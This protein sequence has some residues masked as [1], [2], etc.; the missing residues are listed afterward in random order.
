MSIPTVWSHGGIRLEDTDF[1]SHVAARHQD[2]II[3]LTV[4]T[5]HA[6]T[7][8]L[9]LTNH[10]RRFGIGMVQKTGGCSK[11]KPWSG[12]GRSQGEF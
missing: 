3:I 10:Q 8:I 4:P 2:V 6:D 9:V 11:D 7:K 12:D 1:R 5:K